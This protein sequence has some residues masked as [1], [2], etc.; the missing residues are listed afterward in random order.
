MRQH[1]ALEGELGRGALSEDS[2]VGR[3]LGLGWEQGAA[4]LGPGPAPA[5]RPRRLAAA[6]E[7]G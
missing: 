2:G 1:N 6:L 4:L 3:P 7:D 5:Q